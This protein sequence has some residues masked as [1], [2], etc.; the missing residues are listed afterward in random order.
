MPSTTAPIAYLCAEYAL[1]SN[2]PWYAGGLGVLAG[3]TLK[4]AADEHFPLVGIGILYRGDGFIQKISSD[5]LQ[6]EEDAPFDPVAVGLEHVYVDEMPLFIKVH[7]TEIDVWMRCWKKV[8]SPEVTLYLLDTDTEQNELS[9]RSITHLLYSGTEESVLKQ[10]LILGIGGVKLLHALNIFPQLFHIQEG[11]PTFAHWQLV[12]ILM[13]THGLS[14]LEAVQK[15]KERTVYT[16]HTL[17]AAGN[18]SCD[19]S[20]LK[21]YAS[22]YAGKMGI[23]VETLLQ[24]GVQE[25][26]EDRF[27]L[28]RFA[29]ATSRAAS[30]VSRS[31][32]LLSQQS[33]PQAKWVATTN[34]IHLPSWQS[35]SI[36]QASNKSELWAAHNSEKQKTMEYVRSRTGYGYNPDALV[37]T[38]ARRLAGYKHS[39]ALFTDVARIKA[40]VSRTDQPIQI[41]LAGKAH[42]LDTAGKQQ[43]QTLIHL[44]QTELEG[45]ALFVPNYDLELAAHLVKGSDIWLNTPE[46][47]KEA[48]GT[49]GMKA[50]SNGVLN[51]T[52][53]DGWAAELD[54]T[55]KGWVIDHARS[56]ES[57]YELLEHSIVPM[58][59]KRDEM[60]VPAEWA[61]MMM[62]ARNASQFVSAARMLEEYREKL[63]S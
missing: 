2:L 16:N 8:L 52:V 63:Y 33:W 13:D 6:T 62:N 21:R 45:H 4:Q 60:D 18:P 1:E 7:L 41:L 31:H 10:Q 32:T 9:E 59:Y 12:R 29:L 19:L 27:Y 49:S 51:L 50:L 23:S 53:A 11:R 36:K 56:V 28:T 34:G 5:G 30:G 24:P 15:A 47:G 38:W 58:Y 61:E 14:Y 26:E 57:V 20:L 54:W 3:D 40:L 43:L 17:V 22:Y 25:G 48:C 46:Y 37:L 44:F 39:E 55:G 35:P 42:R